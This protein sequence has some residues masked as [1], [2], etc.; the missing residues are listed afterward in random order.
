[1]VRLVFVALIIGFTLYMGF[2]VYNAAE[3]LTNRIQSQGLSEQD[4]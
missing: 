2:K 3:S 4:D 1:M